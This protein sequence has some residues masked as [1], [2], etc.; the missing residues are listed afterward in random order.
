MIADFARQIVQGYAAPRASARGILSANLSFS[1]AI[2]I[3]V[4]AYVIEAVSQ[5]LVPGARMGEETSVISRHGLGLITQIAILFAIAGLVSG[6]GRAAGGT[7]TYA[8][9]LVIIAWHALVT[10]FLSPLALYAVVQMQG[11]DFQDPDAS[12]GTGSLVALFLFAGMWL[13]LLASYICELHGF[14]NIAGVM[15]AVV[16][17]SMGAS[18]L[19]GVVVSG[20]G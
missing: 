19:L 15:G 10:S 12:L 11:I 13:W 20:L 16:V 1:D 2:L 7:G 8:Q 4:L 14:K 17:I 5:I 6:F 18:L 9:S 3:V